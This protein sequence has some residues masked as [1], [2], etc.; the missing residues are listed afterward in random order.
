MDNWA[1]GDVSMCDTKEH[2]A[3]SLSQTFSKVDTHLECQNPL[4]T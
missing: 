2:T 4:L 3:N 1:D